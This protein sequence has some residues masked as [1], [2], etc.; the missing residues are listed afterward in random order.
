MKILVSSSKAYQSL[1]ASEKEA[2]HKW[3]GKSVVT[4]DGEPLRVYHGTT[5]VVNEFETKYLGN[6]VDEHG[7]G[8]Y[9][10]DV[11]AIASGYTQLS[12]TDMDRRTLSDMKTGLNPNVMPVYL[13]IQRPLDAD[14]Q[15][16]ITPTQVRKLMWGLGAKNVKRFIADTFDM[17]IMSFESAVREYVSYYDGYP[18]LKASLSI[19]SDIYQGHD[20]Q[21][22][23]ARIF[24]E[25]TRYDGV[26]RKTSSSTIYVVF[27]PNQIKS[28]IGNKGTFKRNAKITE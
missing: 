20:L 13:R 10:V 22:E 28:A 3:F 1:T 24:K 25:T 9:F 19:F 4:R 16:D 11:P 15:P 14:K 23:F 18:L 8:F 6:G 12:S 5:N 2:F 17:G 21:G 27:S 26:I 7:V